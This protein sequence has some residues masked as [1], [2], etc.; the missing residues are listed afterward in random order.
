MDTTRPPLDDAQLAA[1]IP[2]IVDSDMAR[3][4]RG[5]V[6]STPAPSPT[7]VIPALR[8]ALANA[9]YPDGFDLT[10]ASPFAYET[11]VLTKWLAVYG[12]ETRLVAPGEPAH[13]IIINLPP[14]P[15]ANAIP[16]YTLPVSYRAVD[17]LTITFTPSGF[18]IAT[19]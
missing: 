17:G 4:D 11:E 6:F 5:L 8:E 14:D 15:N 13:L 9:G 18:P 1:L 16:L 12:I 19:R 2:Q 7:Q 10:L 3:M